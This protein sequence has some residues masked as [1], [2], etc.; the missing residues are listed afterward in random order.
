MLKIKSSKWNQQFL[1]KIKSNCGIFIPIRMD[2]RLSWCNR[3]LDVFN[4]HVFFHSLFVDNRFHFHVCFFFFSGA[5][6]PRSADTRGRLITG[7]GEEFSSLNVCPPFFFRVFLPF[8]ENILAGLMTGTDPDWRCM[9]L[10]M[11]AQIKMSPAACPSNSLALCPGLSQE[12]QPDLSIWC[13]QHGAGRFI[14]TSPSL[15]SLSQ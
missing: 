11:A 4:Q 10:H 14:D 1:A 2:I 5:W 7:L 6:N 15:N 9:P 12:L 13:S 8:S 3:L